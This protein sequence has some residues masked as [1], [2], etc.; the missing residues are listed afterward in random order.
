MDNP[1]KSRLRSSNYL[2][3]HVML[4][5]SRI[6]GLHNPFTDPRDDKKLPD[7]RSQNG[8]LEFGGQTFILEEIT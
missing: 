4:I 1:V 3:K 5:R 8:M 2:S 6:P 7:A